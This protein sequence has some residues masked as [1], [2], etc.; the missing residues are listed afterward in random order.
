LALSALIAF[1]VYSVAFGHMPVRLGRGVGGPALS[2]AVAG[3]FVA[4]AAGVILYRLWKD[5]TIAD[6]KPGK[7][8]AFPSVLGGEEDDNRRS[9]KA[10]SSEGEPGAR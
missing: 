10:E 9:N 2:P 5:V 4:V 7:S 8:G 6:L 1:V 3:I